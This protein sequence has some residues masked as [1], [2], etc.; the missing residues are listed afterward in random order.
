MAKSNILGYPRIG[1]KR[2]LKRANEQFWAGKITAE[3]LQKVAKE[4]RTHN[5]K[6]QKEAGIDLIPS[7][8][9]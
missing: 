6:L 2:E 9:F 4:I 7:N 8:D 1:E 5:W 3:E